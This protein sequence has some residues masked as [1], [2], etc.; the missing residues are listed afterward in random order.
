VLRKIAAV[1][2]CAMLSACVTVPP[3][4]L[5]QTA[6]EA[7]FVKDVQTAW[8]VPAPKKPRTAEQQTK[9]ETGTADLDTRLKASVAQAFSVSP[10]GAEPVTFK[11]NV[12]QANPGFLGSV[13][14]DVDVV[15]ISDGAILGAYTDVMGADTSGGNGGL[16]GLAIA[17]AMKPDSVGIMS[18]N[19]AANLRARF[20]AKK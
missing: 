19:F 17:A 11:V 16:L 18:N 10:A 13:A 4:P 15:R 3:N 12:K 20:D 7:M 9:Y 5:T 2:A 6:R 1:V 14:A 8:A